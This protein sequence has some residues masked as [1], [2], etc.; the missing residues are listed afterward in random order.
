[1]EYYMIRG[2]IY[3]YLGENELDRIYHDSARMVAEKRLAENPDN[4]PNLMMSLAST[5]ASLGRNEEAIRYGEAAAEMMPLSKDALDGASMMFALTGV[6]IR[7]GEHEKAIDLLEYLLEVPSTVQVSF[8]RLHPIYDPLRDN[9][10][11]QA[12]LEKYQ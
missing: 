3:F 11:F 1:M 7:T 2:E 12:L 9:P 8:I 10:R 5:L 6:Y 4:E